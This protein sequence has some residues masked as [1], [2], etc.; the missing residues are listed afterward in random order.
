MRYVTCDVFTADPFT[1]NPLAVVLA[2]DGL[3]AVQMQRIAAEFGYSETVFVLSP[4]GP[5]S[6]ARLRIF[7]PRTELGFAGH[8]IVGTSLVLA[9]GDRELTFEVPAGQ[10]VVQVRSSSA[11]VAAPAG[12]EVLGSADAAA[13][14]RAVGLE[15]AEVLG[16]P[17]AATCGTPFLVAQTIALDRARPGGTDDVGATGLLLYERAG[18]DVRARVFAP[19]LGI[20]EDPAT[21]SAALVLA[22]LLA[23]ELG[24][25]SWRVQ[26]GAQ[27]GRPSQLHAGGDGAGG[28]WVEGSAVVVMR[29][30]LEALP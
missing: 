25:G 14:A 10:V 23:R 19:A 2:A 16:D 7:T 22:G 9:E 6:D 27:M 29:G 21:G 5:G 18:V 26:Q 1:G 15:P 28:T 8:P 3:N 17:V 24:A 20:P 4:T 11:R 12:F 13:V 30:E